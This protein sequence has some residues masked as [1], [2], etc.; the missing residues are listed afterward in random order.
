MELDRL[1]DGNLSCGSFGYMSRST[2]TPTTWEV[3]MDHVHAGDQT[4]KVTG[5]ELVENQIKKQTLLLS[6]RQI[7]EK[8]RPFLLLR[9]RPMAEEIKFPL[10]LKLKG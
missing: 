8:G 3:P 10:P 1:K 7:A 6:L 9:L 2:K 5:S 4:V